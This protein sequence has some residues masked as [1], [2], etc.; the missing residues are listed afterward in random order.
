MPNIQYDAIEPEE[1]SELEMTERGVEVGVFRD[2]VSDVLLKTYF[3][4]MK[5][6]G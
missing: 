3:L 6:Y 2:H 1:I 5:Y 4:L